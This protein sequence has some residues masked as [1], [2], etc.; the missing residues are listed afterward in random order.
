MQACPRVLI[1][2][3]FRIVV[4]Q[5]HMLFRSTDSSDINYHNRDFRV[6]DIAFGVGRVG[7]KDS[8]SPLPS[9]NTP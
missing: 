5:L 4:P 2:T 8:P 9:F 7:W 3:L 6:V 1:N